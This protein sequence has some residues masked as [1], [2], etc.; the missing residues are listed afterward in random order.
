MHATESIG[1]RQINNFSMFYL[2]KCYSGPRDFLF[3]FYLDN[4]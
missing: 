3:Y 4:S 2:G 1:L